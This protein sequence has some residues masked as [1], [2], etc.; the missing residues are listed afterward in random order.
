MFQW[1]E[2]IVRVLTKVY[3]DSKASNRTSSCEPRG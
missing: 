1:I 2:A 3:W